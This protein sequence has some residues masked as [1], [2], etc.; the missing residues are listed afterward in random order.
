[1]SK[2]CGSASVK[3]RKTE[4]RGKDCMGEVDVK[5]TFDAL[6]PDAESEINI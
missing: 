1:M 2:D 6:L 5:E 4:K 3:R